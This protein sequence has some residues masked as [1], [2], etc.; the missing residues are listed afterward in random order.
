MALRQVTRG[1][2]L[3]GFAAGLAL[4]VVGVASLRPSASADVGYIAD[5][6]ATSSA[7][8][9]AQIAGAPSIGNAPAIGTPP[10]PVG[11]TIPVAAS[12]TLPVAGSQ[13]TSVPAPAP[14]VAVSPVPLVPEVS[15]PPPA[16]PSAAEPHRQI[17]TLA[18]PVRL[19]LPELAV[20]AKIT[21]VSV[22]LAGALEVP[23]DPN[24]LGWWDSG[25][26]PGRGR[27]SIVIDG[28]VDSAT[29]GVGAFAR[30]RDLQPG[31]AVLIETASGEVLRYQV[32]G[33]RQFAK[34]ELP[35]ETIFSQDVQERLVLVTCG[36]KFDPAAGHYS[37]NVVVFAVPG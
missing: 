4:V 21:P 36:G 25:A 17:P 34:A 13:D 16:A 33:R 14:A 30:L 6:P 19:E 2:A 3:A 9:A 1:T 23:P 5:A 18:R 35:A 27:G 22:D 29:Q 20:S 32:T 24:V 15:G 11:G 28:H 8:V 37:D 12:G 26:L 10:V 7:A 31:D